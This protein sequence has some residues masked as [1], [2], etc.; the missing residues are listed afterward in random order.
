MTVFKE[1]KKADKSGVTQF[2]R[3]SAE[4][5]TVETNTAP[6]FYTFKG[7][8]STRTELPTSNLSTGDAYYIEDEDKVVFWTS[9]E[10]ANVETYAINYNY[11]NA[12]NKPSINGHVLKGQMTAE[13]LDLQPAGDY[14]TEVPS[15]YIT[16]DE[17]A[18]E[19][20]A[21]KTYVMDQINNA[22]HF[23]REIVDAL[24][25]T[26]KDNVLYLVPK[27]GSNKDVYN[28]YIWTGTD[29]ELMGTTA[30]DLSDYY[31]KE[32]ADKLLDKKVDKVSG[33]GLSTNDYTNAEKTKLASLEN[34]DDTQIK[35]ELATL[36]N[37]DDTDIKNDI[38]ALKTA[39]NGLKM[40]VSDIK[41]ELKDKI[42]GVRL[43]RSG[44]MWDFYTVGGTRLTYETAR[45]LLG[46]PNT[47]LYMEGV[48]ND[49]K[50]TPADYDIDEELIHVYYMDEDG[51]DRY[52]QMGYPNTA[53]AEGS[54]IHI[55]DAVAQPLNSLILDGK[56]EQDV[57]VQGKNYYTGNKLTN[58]TNHGITY[59][60]DNSILKL[61]GTS[62]DSGSIVSDG[63]TKITIPAGTYAYSMRK[64]SGSF[65]QNNKDL[66]IYLRS[67]TDFITAGD[68]TSSGLTLN[69]I[70]SSESVKKI[71]TVST[72]TELYIRI[73]VN[74]SGLVC[75]NL[76]LEIQIEPGSSM[77]DFEQFIPNSPSPDYP[78]EIKIVQGDENG[79]LKVKKIGENLHNIQKWLKTSFEIANGTLNSKTSNSI[80]LTSTADDC[81]TAT[82]SMS[83]ITNKP[84]ID[85]FGLEVEEDTNYTLYT[86]KSNTTSGGNY[87]FY[88]DKDYK[89]IAWKSNKSVTDENFLN[90]TTP[91]KTKYICFRLGIEKSGNTVEFSNIMLLQ[92]TITT[93]PDYVPYTEKITNIDL[94]GNELCSLPNGTKDELIIE[95]NRV[96]I[97]KKIG[98]IVL[99]GKDN[100]V[101]MI[102]LHNGS[103]YVTAN[104]Y[105][106]SI[107]KIPEAA[108][109]YTVSDKLRGAS[110]GSTWAGKEYF[111]ISQ[112]NNGRYLQLCLPQSYKDLSFTTQESIN[113]YL[114][115]NPIT[116]YFL[117]AEPK[118]ID[119][120]EIDM[121]ATF[122]GINNITTHNNVSPNIKVDYI[123]NV[124]YLDKN[125]G[126]KNHYIGYYE[127]TANLPTGNKGDIATVSSDKRIYINDGNEWVPSDKNSTIDLSNYLAKDNTTGYA[128][129]GNYNPATKKYVDDSIK[130]INIPTKTSQLTNDSNF[131]I[132]TTNELTNYY[133]KNNTYT[134]NEVNALVAGGGGGSNV[135]ITVSG[136]TLVITT[137]QGGE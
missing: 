39:E 128:P 116:T 16:E 77:T 132:K 99:D 5:A 8:V 90:F 41:E 53:S 87:V 133:T 2:F 36:H 28:E 7:N 80:S 134:K 92:G 107:A 32:E 136:D 103:K 106:N 63:N 47:I 25:L 115:A 111:T 10:W 93:T 69:S 43:V 85:N 58:G 46:H 4:N 30:V 17:L 71:I 82:F 78:S 20:Y 135:S 83:A 33:K 122:E 66:A 84:R 126:F 1:I 9:G 104:I 127:D 110:L 3:L 59:T 129:T 123:T 130:G 26:G 97:N 23:H 70:S 24:P 101:T 31:T 125:I 120:G 89:F 109:R 56:C 137:E 79:K 91:L 112:A 75:D 124:N 100:K 54:Y 67:A 113:N 27:K 37:Y 29:Y 21:S 14:L 68:G 74:G 35:A 81:Y 65:T 108:V 96:K 22:E 55:E 105:N 34:Y 15:E 12:S 118:T 60:F 62:S 49:G 38:T 121:P 117:L 44:D 95:N 72:D 13:D 6:D 76:E 52:L 119:L 102:G 114:A 42:E 88:Y 51:E 19:D 131:V 64:K 61:N 98:K 40:D 57:T 94:K 11:E 86:K 73:F 50:T 18:A 48:E 45:E